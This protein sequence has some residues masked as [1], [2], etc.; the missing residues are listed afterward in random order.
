MNIEKALQERSPNQETLYLPK[1]SKED[2]YNQIISDLTSATDAL[3][4]E[5]YIVGRP[6]SYAANGYLAKVYMKMATESGLSKTSQEYWDLAY[7]N[8]KLVY[9]AKKYNLLTNYGDLFEEGNENTQESI[10]EIQYF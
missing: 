7:Q 10:F 5:D 8:A 2:V 1:S 6:L 3:P 9:D 4:S